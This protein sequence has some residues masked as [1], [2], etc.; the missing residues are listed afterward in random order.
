MKYLTKLSKFNTRSFKFSMSAILYVL[1]LMTNGQ[2]SADFSALQINGTAN[3]L[4]FSETL[5]C[6]QNVQIE[7]MHYAG[8][9]MLTTQ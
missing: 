3:V 5:K 6:A 7:Q 9:G 8:T 2:H 1:R 4:K